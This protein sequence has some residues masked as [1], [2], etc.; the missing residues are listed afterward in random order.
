M[1]PK[2]ARKS[3][4]VT[5]SF[6]DFDMSPKPLFEK[7]SVKRPRSSSIFDNKIPRKR[8]AGKLWVDNSSPRTRDDLCVHKK[9]VQEVESWLVESMAGMKGRR[10]LLLTG[11]PGC[12]KTATIKLLAKEARLDV[13]EWIN[14][15]I[16]HYDKTYEEEGRPFIKGDYVPES[17]QVTQFTDFLLRANKYT[18]ICSVAKTSQNL[19]L[20]EEFP[21]TFLRDPKPF[22][23][24]L[25]RYQHVGKSPIV[26]I[27]TDNTQQECSVR[28]MFPAELQQELS[29]CN[30]SFNPIATGLLVKALTRAVNLEGIPVPKKEALEALAEASGGDVRGAINALQFGAQKDVSNLQ[31]LF[32]GSHTLART[33]SR[34]KNRIK[35]NH[36]KKLKTESQDH[37]DKMAAIGG[38]D[39]TLI[40]YRAL[41]KILY[42]KREKVDGI[43]SSLP[44]H[45]QNHERPPLQEQDVESIFDKAALGASTFTLFLHQNFLPFYDDIRAV[46]RA[47]DYL[48]DS[49]V[50][51]SDWLGREVLGDYGGSIT[52]RGLMHSNFSTRPKSAT[53]SW[54]PLYKP[55]WFSVYKEGNK[56]QYALKHHHRYKHLSY[57]TSEELATVEAPYCVR[58]SQLRKHFEASI[59]KEVSNFNFRTNQSYSVERLDEKENEDI[60]G[61][62]SLNISAADLYAPE[63]S[64]NTSCSQEKQEDP[65][66]EFIIEEFDE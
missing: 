37:E 15:V 9:K 46:G 4:W 10:F 53:H 19:I 58:I 48:T 14:P 28:R 57:V 44:G 2:G 11:P 61:N 38:K 63:N 64:Q 27:M 39:S 52:V 1:D 55:H 25:H 24:I 20:M 60:E 18:D 47:L 65:D 36:G 13:R 23:N 26:F 16:G 43:V 3:N 59:M 12:G 49:D 54:Q 35:P 51:S 6:D 21:N 22:H 7:K 42:C 5:P 32:T 40:L 56:R 66:E 50:I 34:S 30:I 8:E 45:L 17:N 29:F 31:D 41:G 33:T 62:E